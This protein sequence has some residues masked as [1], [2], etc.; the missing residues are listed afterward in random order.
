MTIKKYSIANLELLDN[1][2]PE[3]LEEKQKQ[4]QDEQ[5]KEDKT[6]GDNS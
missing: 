6:E 4:E 5:V 1:D 3:W 2:N